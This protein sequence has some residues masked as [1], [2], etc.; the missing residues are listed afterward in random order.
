[1]KPYF[2]VQVRLDSSRLPGKVLQTVAPDLTM[3][4]LLHSR[5]C[6]SRFYHSERLIYLTTNSEADD[7]LVSFLEANGYHYMRGSETDVFDR[8][9]EACR[10][11]D[12]SLFF[13]ICGDNP[14]LEPVYLDRLIAE[15]EDHPDLDYISFADENGRPVIKTHYGFFGELI[16]GAAFRKMADGQLSPLAREHVTPLFYEDRKHYRIRLL[17]MDPALVNPSIRLTVDTPADLNNIRSIM[18]ELPPDFHIQQVYHIV[19]GNDKMLERM[20]TLIR[21]HNK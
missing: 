16:S 10:Q 14:F 1:M 12:P 19:A 5:I 15:A 17:P 4:E 6:L 9:Q 8:F 20:S 7:A 21:D 13:R 3:L 11:Y 18:A 2:F